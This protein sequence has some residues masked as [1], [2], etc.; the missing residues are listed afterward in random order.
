MRICRTLHAFKLGGTDTGRT[1]RVA[2]TL[3]TSKRF[4]VAKCGPTFCVFNTID[5]LIQFRM[6]HPHLTPGLTAATIVTFTGA[7]DIG[8]GRNISVWSRTGSRAS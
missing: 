7:T 3:H 6:T 4:G 8:L 2:Q 1:L 5:A